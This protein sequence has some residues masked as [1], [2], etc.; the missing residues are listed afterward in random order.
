[1]KSLEIDKTTNL[2]HLNIR[3]FDNMNFSPSISRLLYYKPIVID[4][5]VNQLAEV[6]KSVI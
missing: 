1:M 2:P 6:F 3:I 5:E 4:S